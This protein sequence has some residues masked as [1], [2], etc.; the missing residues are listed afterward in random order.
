MRRALVVLWLWVAVTP[1]VASP[2]ETCVQVHTDVADVG[3]LRKLVELEVGRHPTHQ[4]AAGACESYVRIEL[5]KIG[6]TRYVTGRINA[7]VPHREQVEGDDVAGA[8]EET[9]RVI[10]H[11]DPV[12]LRGPRRRNWAQ[13]QL[14][15]LR[16]G[17]T[18]FGVEVFQVM[19]VDGDTGLQSLPGLG[20]SIRR[21]V[22]E[23]QIGA[24]LA[25]A[26]RLD[27]TP[28]RALTL[29]GGLQLGAS[30]FFG[31]GDTALYVGPVAGLAFQR[32]EGPSAI[33]G[34]TTTFD[35]LGFAA[36]GRAGVELL[37]TT[38]ARLDL[39]AQVLVPVFTASDDEEGVVDGWYPTASV[40]VGLLL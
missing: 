35:A 40:G 11:N 28:E 7:Q 14:D 23:W 9:L 13:R 21:E 12:R 15:T 39:F 31:D 4:I 37:R 3:Q 27:D 38:R 33:D 36:G 16:T 17:R 26:G 32:F 10:L 8:V 22:A 2:T 34:R 6:E 29:D 30:W 25:L 18:A 19:A 20:L 5:L 1:A 24:R